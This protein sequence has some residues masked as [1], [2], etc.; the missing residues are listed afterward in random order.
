LSK[1]GD[2][3]SSRHRI[4]GVEILPITGEVSYQKFGFPSIYGKDPALP[5][6]S[7]TPSKFSDLVDTVGQRG[8]NPC[9]H[10]H[11]NAIGGSH[12]FSCPDNS[13]PPYWPDFQSRIRLEDF[14]QLKESMSGAAEDEK[15]DDWKYHAFSK[16]TVQFPPEMSLANSLF[17]LKN[18]LKEFVPLMEDLKQS[19]AGNF[20]KFKFGVM[21]VIKDIRDSLNVWDKFS[22]RMSF[23]QDTRGKTFRKHSRFKVEKDATDLTFEY[24]WWHIPDPALLPPVPNPLLDKAYYAHDTFTT[25]RCETLQAEWWLVGIIS[26][27]IG[28]MDSL[29]R[30]ADA[31]GRVLG[32][33]NLPKIAW[34]AAKWTWI[35]DW[36]VD[37]DK[38]LD[39]FDDK[40]PFEGKLALNGCFLGSRYKLFGSLACRCMHGNEQ[41]FGSFL[42]RDYSRVTGITADDLDSSL[43]Q[44]SL[45]GDQ[46]AILLALLSQRT[47]AIPDWTSLYKKFAKMR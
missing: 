28:E 12:S 5:A 4:K 47:R 10:L 41:E 9:S 35:I 18:G 16:F 6:L 39:K 36:F 3:L 29:S 46:Q 17:E 44:P 14:Y 40:G 22:K 23:L 7:F 8:W 37:T 45:D 31:F 24:D 1:K 34:N 25:Y 2:T 27:M 42:L 38:I 26:N 43:V 13:I 30:Q 11:I 19:I 20:L 33:S 32:L 15:Y 21:P